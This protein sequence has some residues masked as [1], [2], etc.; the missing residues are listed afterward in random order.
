MRGRGWHL[1]SFLMLWLRDFRGK[2]LGDATRRWDQSRAYGGVNTEYRNK[3]EDRK[4][5]K[6]GGA[7]SDTPRELQIVFGHGR[8]VTNRKS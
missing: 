6:V 7:V 4:F 5:G 2:E 1:R 8:Q 3:E